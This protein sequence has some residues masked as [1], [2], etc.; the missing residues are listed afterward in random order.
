MY[1]SLTS[2]PLKPSDS[3]APPLPA[4]KKKKN[5]GWAT[6]LSA[7]ETDWTLDFSFFKVIIDLTEAG[8]G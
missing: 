8:H 5:A 1:D 7:G 4:G 3:V 2:P 6:G